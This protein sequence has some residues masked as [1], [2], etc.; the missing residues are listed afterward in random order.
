[1]VLLGIAVINV[2]DGAVQPAYPVKSAVKVVLF[3][4][5]PAVY[6]RYVDRELNL[7]ALKLGQSFNQ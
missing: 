2:L 5:L 4:G 7:K 3:G 6:D 1:M